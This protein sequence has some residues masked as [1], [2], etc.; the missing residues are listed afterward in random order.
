VNQLIIAYGHIDQETISRLSKIEAKILALSLPAMVSLDKSGMSYCTVRDFYSIKKYR[1]DVNDLI[2]QTEKTL[3]EC[4]ALINKQ[5]SIPFTFSGNI[6]YFLCLLADF[7]FI[8]GLIKKIRSARPNRI[9]FVGETIPALKNLEKLAFNELKG[10]PKPH[11]GLSMPI[12]RG[13]HTKVAFLSLGLA[14]IEQQFIQTMPSEGTT[15]AESHANQLTR[16][17]RDF[18]F[19]ARKY[20]SSPFDILRF[21]F[22]RA[23]E[24]ANFGQFKK[25]N[26]LLVVQGGYK[27]RELWRLTP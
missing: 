26:N 6:H 11:G 4:D 25:T 9:I 15:Y 8:E 27:I 7:L 14:A 12:S 18:S 19:L 23:A 5:I 10:T 21:V 13:M 3:Q 2:V 24:F 17:L 1:S 16:L 22:A 20:F